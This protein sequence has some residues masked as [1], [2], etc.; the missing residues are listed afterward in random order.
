MNKLSQTAVTSLVCG[1]VAGLS[2]LAGRK[3]GVEIGKKMANPLSEQI[4]YVKALGDI[5][6][7]IAN[8]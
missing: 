5:A 6:K 4:G 2:F 8:K 7:N 1:A 3:E